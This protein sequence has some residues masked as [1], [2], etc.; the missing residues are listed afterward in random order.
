MKSNLRFSKNEPVSRADVPKEL[1]EIKKIIN[2][3]KTKLEEM[4][5]NVALQ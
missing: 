4:Q 3:K 1:T 2:A 5:V